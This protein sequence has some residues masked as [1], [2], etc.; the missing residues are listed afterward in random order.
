M[1]HSPPETDPPLKAD[2]ASRLLVWYGQKGRALPWR[3]TRDP[4]RIW[5]S[6]IMLQQTGVGTVIPY[7]AE[8]LARF[9]DLC[10]LA[11][12]DLDEVIAAWSGLGYYSRARHLHA[13]AIIVRDRFGGRLPDDLDSLMAL[14][15][16]GR[17]TAG[18]ILAIAFHHK[19]PI[20]DG[21]VRR[22]LCR[23]FAVG[24]DPRCPTVEK[25]LW[26]WAE[27]LLPEENPH[28]YT[29]AIMDLGATLCTPRHPAC[30]CCPVKSCCLA[31]RL[32]K[33][34]ELP[35][36]RRGKSLPRR[37]ESALVLFRQGHC[38]VQKRPYEG[39]L[40]GLWEFPNIEVGL[41]DKAKHTAEKLMA[42]LGAKGKLQSRGKISHAYSHF[43]L[44]SEVFSAEVDPQ[45]AE[46]RESFQA[47][48]PVTKLVFLHLHGAHKKVLHLCQN[49]MIDERQ[50]DSFDRKH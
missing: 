50:A 28:D 49:R 19:A 33:T 36:R 45:C 8:F 5:I 22:I 14:P 48:I 12:A 7:Y 6:E 13:A 31:Y 16:I 17:S 41:D 29:Q 26:Q 18:A 27:E 38:L 32:G 10:A 34:N 47:W 23:L 43:H 44:D 20:L 37:R 25:K 39:M 3:K 30:E 9:P 1:N 46:I 4:Y 24:E 21:N 2:F 40:G 42:S 11:A 15:G 35:V